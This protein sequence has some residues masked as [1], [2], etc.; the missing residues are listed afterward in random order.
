MLI[1]KDIDPTQTKS[2]KKLE[3]HFDEIKDQTLIELFKKEPNRLEYLSFDWGNFYF[4]FSKNHLTKK[5][6]HYL[7]HSLRK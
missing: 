1:F 2:W 7:N 4:D 6:Y 5:L 3:Q